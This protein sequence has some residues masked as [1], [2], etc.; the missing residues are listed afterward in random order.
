VA[1]GITDNLALSML[2]GCMGVDMPIVAAP[3]VNPSIARHPAFQRAVAELRSWGVRVL[4][5]RSAPPPTCMVS[6]E[7]ILQELVSGS[8][9]SLPIFAPFAVGRLRQSD[10]PFFA[11][12]L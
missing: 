1:V 11:A 4:Y 12:S 10:V 8:Y 2:Y 9:I 5:E 6:W 7:R 3:N